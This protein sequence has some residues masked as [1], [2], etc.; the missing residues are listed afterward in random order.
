MHT[1]RL[2][3]SDKVYDKFIWFLSKFSKEKVEI[4]Q[5]SE[6]YDRNKAYLH[7]ELNEIN[8]GK[9]IFLNQKEFEDRLD[10]II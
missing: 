9:A 5:E 6:E 7:E 10:Q 3:I 8:E 4:V 2:K 1:I